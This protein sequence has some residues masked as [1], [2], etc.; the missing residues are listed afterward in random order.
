M[1]NKS[2][3]IKKK[4]RN[5][6]FSIITVVKNDQKNIKSTIKSI[7]AQKFRKFEYIVIDGNSKDRTIDQI[8]KLKNS[9][10]L[11]ITENDKGLYDA[12]NK[13]VKHSKGRVIVFVNSG[14]LLTKN[15]LKIIYKIFLKNEKI[16]FVFG[17]V[18]RK[19]TKGTLLKSG[20]N[21]KKL[22]YNFDFATSHSTG[23][24][25]KK[26]SFKKIGLFNLKYKCSA[27]YDLYFRAIIKN[28]FKGLSNNKSELIGI[29]Q[30]GGFSSK[31]SFLEHLIEETKIRIDNKQNIFIILMIIIN[32]LIKKFL[33]LMNLEKVFF[34]VF[35][36]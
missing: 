26:K 25:L 2:V 7:K 35:G 30:S 34:P 5:P 21:K 13:G 22:Y 24:F 23:F 11:L 4:I 32:S 3:I 19:Y 33:K 15:A 31:F 10:N 27:D 6:Y 28:N 1:K 17:T 18:R 14:D 36:K 8:I 16:D 12:M 20:F 29:V 9:V